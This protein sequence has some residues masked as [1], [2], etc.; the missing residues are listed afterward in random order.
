MASSP[1]QIYRAGNSYLSD[2]ASL[3]LVP[4]GHPEGYLEAF[5]LYKNC[6]D[7]ICK[8]RRKRTNR[9]NA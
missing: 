9:T 1:G 6:F 7:I 3:I 8:I 4:P 5:N 2:S